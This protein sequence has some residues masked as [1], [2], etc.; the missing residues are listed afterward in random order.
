[1]LQSAILVVGIIFIVTTL[2][3]D[4]LTSLLNPRIRVAKAEA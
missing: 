3:A 4:L 1:M 2:V